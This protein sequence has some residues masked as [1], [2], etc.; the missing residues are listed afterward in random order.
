MNGV[1]NGD[2]LPD[3]RRLTATNRSA[4]KVLFRSACRRAW[5]PSTEDRMTPEDS[6][7]TEQPRPGEWE[8]MGRASARRWRWPCIIEQDDEEEDEC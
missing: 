6:E 8:V 1:D 5:R 2:E 3:E 4:T 7:G